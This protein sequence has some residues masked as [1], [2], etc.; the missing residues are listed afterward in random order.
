MILPAMHGLLIITA[1]IAILTF[2]S[3]IIHKI[4]R[5][6]V[7]QHLISYCFR[8][9]NTPNAA[10]RE[11]LTRKALQAAMQDYAIIPLYQYTYFRLIKPNVGGYIPKNQP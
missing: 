7:H 8:Q 4:M 9:Q 6:H 5:T 10:Q 11:D 1:L 3:A 2:I